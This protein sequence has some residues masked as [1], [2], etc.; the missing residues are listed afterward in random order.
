MRTPAHH[1][2]GAGDLP[3][4]RFLVEHG[5]DLAA[6]D[7]EYHATPLGWAEFFEQKEAADYLDSLA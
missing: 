2:A 5:A 7:A 4:L 6:V 1:A 3:T